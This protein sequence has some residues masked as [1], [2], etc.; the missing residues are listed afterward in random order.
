MEVFSADQ[1]NTSF[2]SLRLRVVNVSLRSNNKIKV[3]IQDLF[4]RRNFLKSAAL[5]TAAG[6]A[7]PQAVLSAPKQE[8]WQTTVRPKVVFFDVNET[9]LDLAAMK[10]SVGKALGGKVELLPLWFSTML[11]YSLVSTAAGQYH[12][13]GAIGAAALQMVGA[14]NQLRITSAEAKAAMKPILSLPAHPDVKEGLEQLSK[15]GYTLVSFTN[16]SYK[17]VDAQL[18]NAGIFHLF[19]ERISVEG[20]GK[21]KPHTDAYA[22]TAR[23]MGVSPAD[24]LLVAAHGWDVAGAKWAGWQTAFLSRPGQ[25]LFP[26]AQAPDFSFPDLKQLAAR[27]VTL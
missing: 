10:D 6:V 18:Q 26:L 15:A 1:C 17:A 4:S 25:Q 13:F 22:W 21:F 3:L 20:L 7:M 11:H 27:L 8:A 23:K 5:A 12:D 19:T 9:L 16:S 24:C 2:K 14:S